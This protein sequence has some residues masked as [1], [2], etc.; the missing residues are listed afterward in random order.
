MGVTSLG[1][2]YSMGRALSLSDA[3]F[4]LPIDFLRLPC[5]AVVALLAY[6]E[7]IDGWT[8]VGAAVIFAGNYWSVHREARVNPRRAAAPS[9]AP[10]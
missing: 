7:P 6:G 3:S 2:H 9:N 4:V 10:S 5:I 1:A 8:L